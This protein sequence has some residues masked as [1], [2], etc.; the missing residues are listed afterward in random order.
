MADVPPVKVTGMKTAINTNVQVSIAIVTSPIA[1]LVAAYGEVYPLSNLVCTASTTTMAS[2]TTVPIAKT[3][4]KSV[5]RLILNPATERQ[6][7][8]PINET[9]TEMVGISVL[10]KSCKKKYTTMITNKIAS[11][12]VFITSSME[13]YRK[14]FV[15]RISSITQPAGKSSRNSSNK[16]SNSLMISVALEPA[17]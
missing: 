15:L 2:S 3:K 7:K 11:N 4:A 14:S 1:D 10:L 5:N 12:K 16:S 8:V 6:A 9:K 17:V 13:A